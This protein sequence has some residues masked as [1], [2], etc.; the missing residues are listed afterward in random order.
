M[1]TRASKENTR[2]SDLGALTICSVWKGPGVVN[3][4]PEKT[5]LTSM[6]EAWK[7]HQMVGGQLIG[8]KSFKG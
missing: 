6:G 3:P 4:A 1:E 7:W 2:V 5:L 8:T